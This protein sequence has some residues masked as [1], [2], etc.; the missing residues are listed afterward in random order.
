MRMNCEG[1]VR[2]NGKGKASRVA[3]QKDVKNH[4]AGVRARAGRRRVSMIHETTG[5]GATT[6]IG[7][8]TVTVTVATRAEVVEGM[9]VIGGTEVAL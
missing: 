4:E 9:T 5:G 3:A 6:G 7:T 2:G 8:G 1:G